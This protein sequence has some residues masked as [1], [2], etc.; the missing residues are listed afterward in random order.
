MGYEWHQSKPCELSRGYKRDP[1]VEEQ[2]CLWIKLSKKELLYNATIKDRD[3]GNYPRMETLI[4]F[5]RRAIKNGDNAAKD[6][7][8]T[9]VFNRG[10]I[11]VWNSLKHYNIYNHAQLED[12][13]YDVLDDLI[14]NVMDL[15]EKH[16]F[17]EVNFIS[18]V[19]RLITT[20]INSSFKRSKKEI[21]PDQYDD[22]EGNESL[23]DGL[24]DDRNPE[25]IALTKIQYDK[26]T[27]PH[28]LI[29][30]LLEEGYTQ[31]EI[32]TIIGCSSRT[33]RN[34]IKSIR[35]LMQK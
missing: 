12:V 4:H 2:I 27:Y 15:T 16:E 31:E 14:V 17:W 32:A 33:I 8:L 26:L 5:T 11:I 6:I 3:N 24:R 29:V 1:L 19:Q 25:D 20:K 22:D 9:V 13:A 10:K 18:C 28:T 7:L 35:T 34:H 21:H 30:F 23:E